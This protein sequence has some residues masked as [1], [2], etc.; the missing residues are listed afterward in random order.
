MASYSA[1]A[2][3]QTCLLLE[4]TPQD[5]RVMEFH[6]LPQGPIPNFDWN[7]VPPASPS[8]TVDVTQRVDE[9]R[10]YL[11]NDTYPGQGQNIEAAIEMYNRQEL[12]DPDS[13]IVYIKDGELLTELPVRCIQ[14]NSEPVWTEV[15][16][17]SPG[18]M[19]EYL[20][21]YIR[22][23]IIST[24]R[25]LAISGS[26]EFLTHHLLYSRTIPPW[27]AQRYS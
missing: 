21:R 25:Q 1:S 12:P 15:C 2:G 3:L 14:P 26:L 10:E 17:K 13:H 11:N 22:A 20:C 19:L 16:L 8:N 18:N 23:T 9:L 4:D 24:C 6:S 27:M 7:A 5:G